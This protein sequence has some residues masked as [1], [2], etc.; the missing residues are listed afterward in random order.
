[1][2]WLSRSLHKPEHIRPGLP[3]RSFRPVHHGIRCR[4][5]PQLRPSQPEPT[6]S[7]PNCSHNCKFGLPPPSPPEARA[8]LTHT[9]PAPAPPQS[10]TA[11]GP[12]PAPPP[13]PFVPLPAPPPPR[14]R[15]KDNSLV[16]ASAPPFCASIDLRPCG[17]RGCATHPRS[18]VKFVCPSLGFRLG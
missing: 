5:S 15:I 9:L 1:V 3:D 13:P 10:S 12:P 14:T 6:R 4:F 2:C 7:K 8:Q 11:A 18:W 16:P 17:T